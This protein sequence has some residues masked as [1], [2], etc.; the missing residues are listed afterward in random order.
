VQQFERYYI[1]LP[2]AALTRSY[3]GFAEAVVVHCG[4]SCKRRTTK[5]LLLLLLQEVMVS[6]DVAS[7]RRI[8]QH[9]AALRWL[10]GHRDCNIR[11]IC[12][13]T[14]NDSNSQNEN[15]Q[16]EIC[17]HWIWEILCVVVRH[18]D[19]S[20]PSWLIYLSPTNWRDSPTDHKITD[21][22]LPI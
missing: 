8:I 14:A 5:Q 20:I 12:S 4:N 2:T 19:R 17:R 9:P 21:L 18:L 7:Q 16:D 15:C 6:D 13:S 10:N 3:S 1:E 22:I 11:I